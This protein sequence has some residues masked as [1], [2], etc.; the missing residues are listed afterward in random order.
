MKEQKPDVCVAFEGPCPYCNK[1]IEID[2]QK[3]DA[4]GIIRLLK[5]MKPKT[6]VAIQIFKA[7]DEEHG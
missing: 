3:K 5:E 2:I 7:E 1:T 6:R 4:K